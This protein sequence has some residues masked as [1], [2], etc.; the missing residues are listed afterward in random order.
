MSDQ[1]LFAGGCHANADT[2]E[3]ICDGTLG[4]THVR[5]VVTGGNPMFMTRHWP[6]FLRELADAMER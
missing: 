3:S 5:I 4:K 2:Q 1:V 6:E